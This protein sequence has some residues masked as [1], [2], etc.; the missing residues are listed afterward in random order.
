M[1]PEP[2]NGTL[3]VWQMIQQGWVA[4]YP[5]IALSVISFTII[6][7]RLWSLRGLLGGTAALTRAA[8]GDLGKAIRAPPCSTPRRNRV[9]PP[10]ASIRKYSVKAASSRS[11]S[12]S[13]SRASGVSKKWS[14]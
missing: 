3:N 9:R 6:G 5:L 11:K 7:E 14:G 4:C 8:Y 2:V 10:A 1:P 13:S 12:W